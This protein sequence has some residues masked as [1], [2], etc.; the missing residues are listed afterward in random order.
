MNKF[1]KK[2]YILL[3]TITTIIIDYV[4]ITDGTI[5]SKKEPINVIKRSN[6]HIK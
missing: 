6:N 4:M 1:S 5:N 2:S 3:N